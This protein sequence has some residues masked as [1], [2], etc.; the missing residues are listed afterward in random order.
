MRVACGS[1]NLELVRFTILF[2]FLIAGGLAAQTRAFRID[3]AASRLHFA[4]GAS[5]HTVEG[6]FRLEGGKVEIDLATGAASGELSAQAASGNSGS[7][8]RDRRM[9][10]QILEAS[11]YPL[12]AFSPKRI[13]GTLAPAGNSKMEV[14][15]DFQIHGATHP[16]TASAEVSIDKDHFHATTSFLVPY[17]KWGMKD[18]STFFLK[19]KDQVSLS[20]DLVGQ[21]T[22]SP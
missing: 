11:R 4:L 12:I 2:L 6:D 21:T 18:P 7:E 16:L 14:D 22:T 17:V 10:D 20:L 8:T 1:G 15:G 13:R 9:H 19:V 3:P 5:L